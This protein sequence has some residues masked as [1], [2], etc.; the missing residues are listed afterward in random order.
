MLIKQNNIKINNKTVAKN[1]KSYLYILWDISPTLI[2]ISSKLY[3]NKMQLL[4]K[5]KEQSD[6]FVFD[7]V[8]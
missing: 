8:I 6:V 7:I 2:L 1:N 5:K 3:G 4:Q